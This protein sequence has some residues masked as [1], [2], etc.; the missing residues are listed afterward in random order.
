M[1]GWYVDGV[2]G[3]VVF[4]SQAQVGDDRRAVLLHQDVF[5]LEVSVS[6]AGFAYKQTQQMRKITPESWYVSW[7]ERSN[8][9]SN[10]KIERKLEN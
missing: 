7:M 1:V 2:G 5:R 4:H 3:G 9:I 8:M 10:L 6:D